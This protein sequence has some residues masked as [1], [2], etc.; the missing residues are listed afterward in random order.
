M[1]LRRRSS[2]SRHLCSRI[3][4]AIRLSG[5]AVSIEEDLRQPADPDPGSAGPGAQSGTGADILERRSVTRLG[6]T[7]E[8]WAE[9]CRGLRAGLLSTPLLLVLCSAADR[10]AWIRFSRKCFVFCLLA[11]IERTSTPAEIRG[12][13]VTE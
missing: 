8:L 7:G 3:S 6:Q 2:S 13:K 11:M 10:S 9:P 12:E 4:R 1:D 5:A